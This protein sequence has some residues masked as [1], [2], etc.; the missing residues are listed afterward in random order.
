MDAIYSWQE[1]RWAKEFTAR[2]QDA[3]EL[4][5]ERRANR[6]DAMDANCPTWKNRR[7]EEP[8]RKEDPTEEGCEGRAKRRDAKD[9]IGQPRESDRTTR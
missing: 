1:G 5:Q 3:T 7:V 2:E 9:W 8:T 6:Q 4:S